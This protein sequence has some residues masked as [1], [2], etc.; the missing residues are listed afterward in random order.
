MVPLSPTA[1][2]D[3]AAQET[4]L[5]ALV[6]G[7]AC[8]VHVEPPLLVVAIVPPDPTPTHTVTFVQSIF[9]NAWVDV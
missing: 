2:Q 8:D 9:S 5:R 6:V 3:A 4:P 1:Q 7:E